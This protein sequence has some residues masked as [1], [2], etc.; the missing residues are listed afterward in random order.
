MNP[1]NHNHDTCSKAV[2]PMR[3]EALFVPA[4]RRPDV[5]GGILQQAIFHTSISEIVERQR[6]AMR[7]LALSQVPQDNIS[8]IIEVSE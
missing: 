3:T 5:I 1:N 6:L 2:A 7:E 4:R 8:D